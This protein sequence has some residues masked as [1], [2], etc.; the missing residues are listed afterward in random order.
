MLTIYHLES[1]R[2]GRIIWLAEELGIDYVVETFK[3]T[4]EFLPP[5]S[6]RDLHP[7]GRS[8]IVSEGGVLLAESNAI[9]EYLLASADSSHLVP[10]KGSCSYSEY[11]FWLHFAEGS[12]MPHHLALY[13]LDL[14][15]ARGTPIWGNRIEVLRRDLEHVEQTLT[16]QPFLSCDKFAACD[17][18]MHLALLATRQ[19][20]EDLPE[21]PVI[22]AY[23]AKL[24]DRPAY[25]KAAL[26]R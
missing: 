12:L 21:Y 6:Y 26:Y 18:M 15:D 25:R 1:S 24:S 13:A 9:C 3:R 2:S 5:A 22:A 14:A 17:L 8:P 19:F 20:S 10:A 4:A 23:L 7:L 11:L 16:H